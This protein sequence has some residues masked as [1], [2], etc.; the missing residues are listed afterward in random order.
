MSFL[1]KVQAVGNGVKKVFNGIRK[2][3]KK[4][5][6]FTKFMLTAV[7]QVVAI[8]VGIVI[9]IVLV[10]VGIRTVHHKLAKWFNA[11]YG[12]IAAEGDYDVLVGS[13]S[14]AGYDSFITEQNWQDFNAY[15]Y[16]VLIDVA[17]YLY[18][19]QKEYLA[20]NADSYDVIDARTTP[21]ASG[22]GP[23]KA[24]SPKYLPYLPVS[25]EYDITKL[26]YE[27][28][29]KNVLE[30]Q[31]SARFGLSNPGDIGLDGT[32]YTANGG[33]LNCVPPVI[34]YEY[35]ANP[36]QD[37]AGS[38][39]PYITVLREQFKYRYY[40]VGAA[41]DAQQ[42]G[43]GGSATNGKRSNYEGSGKYA[44]NEGNSG[45]N[46]TAENIGD[47]NLME[48]NSLL[49]I[50]NNYL[51]KNTN[52][53]ND[54]MRVQLDNAGNAIP[55][56]EQLVNYSDSANWPVADD[57]FEQQLYYTD[58]YGST[59]YKFPLQQL[60]DRYL[61]KA[62]MLT[63]W[64]TI[65]DGNSDETSQNY[66]FAVKEMM[67]DIKMIYN[68][69]CL[70]KESMASETVSSVQYDEDGKIIRDDDNKAIMEDVDKKYASTNEETF[71]KF[72]QAGLQANRFSVFELYSA[73]GLTSKG[74]SV[75]QC[76]NPNVTLTDVEEV[77]PVVNDLLS[78]N[79]EFLQKF[80]LKVVF[81]YEFSY[82]YNTTITVPP[83]DDD[84][85][86]D[87]KSFK[88]FV[89]TE[90]SDKVEVVKN[91]LYIKE[92]YK[93][94]RKGKFY[95]IVNASVKSSGIQYELIKSKTGGSITVTNTETGSGISDFEVEYKPSDVKETGSR[96]T[97]SDYLFYEAIKTAE[98]SLQE[99]E[100]VKNAQKYAMEKH[101]K[102][103]VN[104]EY[105]F[106]KPGTVEYD[107]KTGEVK[108]KPVDFFEGYH[109]KFPFYNFSVAG[110]DEA[111]K[112]TI[113]NAL[114]DEIESASKAL[115]SIEEFQELLREAATA[116]PNAPNQSNLVSS[117]RDVVPGSFSV[118]ISN[119]RIVGYSDDGKPEYKK[120]KDMEER[121]VF[122]ITEETIT[123]TMNVPQKRM[124]VM[125]VTNVDT[126]A[127]HVTY[128]NK[129]VQNPFVPDNYRFVMPHSYFS[130]G[131]KIFHIT[132]NAKYRY[133]LYS[134]YF[135]KVGNSEPAIKEADIMTMLMSWEK[136][137]EGNETAY[138]FMRD[139]YKLVMCI[140]KNGRILDTAYS[141]LYLSDSIWDF[142]EGITQMKFWTE[143][144]A[145]EPSE[146]SLSQEEQKRM[147]VKKDEIYW[148]V[149]DYEHYDEC[150]NPDGTTKVYAL[151]PHGNPYVRSYFM[152]EAI[153]KGRFNDGGFKN[154]HGGADWSARSITKSIMKQA[155]G[156]AAQVYDYAL[157]Q[158]EMQK[159]INGGRMKTSIIDKVFNTGDTAG[160]EYGSAKEKLDS[161][162]K[163]YSI[164][165]PIV[166]IAPG[167]VM[168]A[169]YNC[170]G[171]FCVTVRHTSGDGATPV[172]SSYVHM[173][174]W[175]NV[176]AGDI[177]G[178]GTIVG[179]EG[180]TGNS[181]G[182]H[183]HM[184]CKVNGK[185]ESPA[186]YMGPIF[187]PF[188]NKEKALEVRAGMS[189]NPKYIIA[190]DYYSLI[191]TVILDKVLETGVPYKEDDVIETNGDL[192]FLQSASFVTQSGER[193]VVV[194]RKEAQ[195]ESILLKKGNQYIVK[196][197]AT[198]PK[199]WLCTIEFENNQGGNDDP[200]M[201]GLL[202]N[203]FLNL[204]SSEGIKLKVIDARE[205]K[206][207]DISMGTISVKT[208]MTSSEMAPVIWGNNVPIYPLIEDIKDAVDASSLN[209]IRR[210]APGDEANGDNT[211][212][213]VKKKD[214]D[215]RASSQFFNMNSAFARERLSL[216]AGLLL[217]MADVE[218]PYVVAF[219]DGPIAIS[220]PVASSNKLPGG[221]VSD[222]IQLQESMKLKM[223]I[224]AEDNITSGEFDAAMETA[225]NNKL[226][227]YLRT[228]EYGPVGTGVLGSLQ[229]Y[230][231]D[232]FK[233][234]NVILYNSAVTYGTYKTA[235]E[236]GHK[237]VYMAA[238]VSGLDPTFLAGVASC[239][240]GFL[241]SNES[242][243]IPGR[244]RGPAERNVMQFEYKGQLKN[245]RRAQGLLQVMPSLAM[246]IYRSKGITD[247]ETMIAMMRT[248]YTNA[249]TGAEYIRSHVNRLNGDPDLYAAV[250]SAAQSPSIIALAKDIGASPEQIV[251]YAA[252]AYMYN[253]G[254]NSKAIKDRS[255]FSRIASIS[256]TDG[257]WSISNAGAMPGYTGKV[258]QYMLSHSI[259]RK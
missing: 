84:Q 143:R 142:D 37:G 219:Y 75:P 38:L 204:G 123:L 3:I 15:E 67:K 71:I 226:F 73:N 186:K 4:I 32:G 240:S 248:P 74:E 119:I 116:S 215:V 34:T 139:L 11:D 182:H 76:T 120:A 1:D 217:R 244:N 259:K 77:V 211:K 231:K 65:K 89:S 57:K 42:V 72:G 225:I 181:G 161:E 178:A 187:A 141:Y 50:Y 241:P 90:D 106:P 113:R 258:L 63:A 190:S 45:V 152:M 250:K 12:G 105:L 191:R 144:L 159:Q 184:G 222:L 140:R 239:E 92:T 180:T 151:F 227:P 31:V 200:Y 121:A 97:I 246:G 174:R 54:V 81:D 91:K 5:A 245:L 85:D 136:Y 102:Q 128:T 255:F 49:N 228:F 160:V 238:V 53:S 220:T 194:D 101:E 13:L 25:V 99:N 125:L 10:M 201:D 210:Y 48:Y 223:L 156:V 131:V 28:W 107:P 24:A 172:Q 104:Y 61:P 88:L 109:Q 8:L 252:S 158:L 2:T 58:S 229:G 213:T 148:Q 95:D 59:A 206:F 29:V 192:K 221:M 203:E 6:N 27:N 247:T 149:V 68:Y 41:G 157:Q 18:Q 19:G 205:V 195:D 132:E 122:D 167:I 111:N 30:G 87:G 69:Y 230:E 127:K 183:L 175:P 80:K 60:I 35:R 253:K 147:K 177:I 164:Y 198:K 114:S 26:T 79:A 202:E 52:V 150:K 46:I 117:S 254:P 207:N 153:E 233:I 166:S 224:T 135:S 108:C 130:F 137:A 103:L 243:E 126:W 196:E 146:D 118:S 64:Y 232:N 100:A 169:E 43:A 176:Q 134:K 7:G 124:S 110:E 33:D 62:S 214:D 138:A 133:D 44:T 170:Y 86:N 98:G 257:S 40:T 39:V 208:T 234:N 162:L 56:S 209:N 115:T 83:S 163:D 23:V 93:G 36:Y 21:A 9:I 212:S 47:I 20:G 145:A 235:I 251:I 112:G 168:K 171:G 129:I 199:Y 179:Y 66:A 236:V 17:E 185:A 165:S 16:S 218:N 242:E 82:D 216:P 155:D 96:E 51:P 154:G 189:N 14:S 188:Y 256:Y 22:R 55:F 78:D 94:I 70:D 249:L 173:K 193:Y 237:A 197:G